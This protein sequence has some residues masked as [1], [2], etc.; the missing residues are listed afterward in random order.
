MR[1]EGPT[2]V[3]RGSVRLESWT[4]GSGERTL[5]VAENRCLRTEEENGAAEEPDG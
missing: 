4:E 2:S 3:I 1:R 5:L